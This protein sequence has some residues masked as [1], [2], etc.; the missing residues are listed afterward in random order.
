VAVTKPAAAYHLTS[1][2]AAKKGLEPTLT[3]RLNEL[4]AAEA[5]P[6]ARLPATHYVRLAPFDHLG[7]DAPGETVE[8]L[9]GTYL[10]V[11]F[12]FDGDPDRYLM[13]LARICRPEVEDI[14]G[15]CGG[16]PGSRDLAAFAGWIRR[17]ECGPLHRFGALPASAPHIRSALDTRQRLIAFAVATQDLPAAELHEAYLK[18]FASP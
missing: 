2:L 17:H 4:S 18:Q 10:L 5:S 11:S 8:D 12:I 16:W 1:I 13:A 7:A 6:F 9:G 15:C 3:A 14:F